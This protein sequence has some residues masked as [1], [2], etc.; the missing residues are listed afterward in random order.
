L[1]RSIRAGGKPVQF[2]V[3]LGSVRVRGQNQIQLKLSLEFESDLAKFF[4]VCSDYN[5]V[6]IGVGL[7]WAWL[8]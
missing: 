8:Y 5:S 4:E 7:N 2:K 6:S 1:D 3:N